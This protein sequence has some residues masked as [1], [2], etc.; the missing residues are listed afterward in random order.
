MSNLTKV[1]INCDM[2]EGFGKWKMVRKVNSERA[3]CAFANAH[4]LQGPDDELIKYVDVANIACGFHAAD[5]SLM[6]KTVRLAKAH[7]KPVGAHPG[8]NGRY[9]SRRLLAVVLVLMC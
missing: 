3:S 5:P 2:G 1:E 6:V 9:L 7:G 8:L 4:Q